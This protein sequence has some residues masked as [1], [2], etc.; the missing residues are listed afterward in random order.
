MSNLSH[1][2]YALREGIEASG[3]ELAVSLLRAA[4]VGR[5][6][7]VQ[8]FEGDLSIEEALAYARMLTEIGDD[9]RAA[10]LYDEIFQACFSP[11]Y[12]VTVLGPAAVA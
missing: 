3:P 11:T 8:L 2:F 7:R 5:D 6:V 1:L 10:E 12:G 9:Q 4:G